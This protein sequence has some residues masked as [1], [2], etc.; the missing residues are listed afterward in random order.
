ML[1]RDSYFQSV[2]TLSGESGFSVM[3][4][5]ALRYS[6]LAM[7]DNLKRK[8]KYNIESKIESC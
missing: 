2:T 1:F 5:M 6:A 4:L 8:K 3:G 7:K